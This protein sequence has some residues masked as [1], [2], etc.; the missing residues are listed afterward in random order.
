MVEID[1]INQPSQIFIMDEMGMQMINKTG[2]V[3]AKKGTKDVH[4]LAGKERG[5]NNHQINP[6]QQQVNGDQA[7]ESNKSNDNRTTSPQP[8]TSRGNEPNAAKTENKKNKIISVT[9]KSTT[10]INPAQKAIKNLCRN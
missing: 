4:I 5:E 10:K 3:I 8:G 7:A 1:F 6:K 9:K 2:K